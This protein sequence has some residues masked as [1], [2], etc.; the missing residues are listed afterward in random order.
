MNQAAFSP[1]IP[2]CSHDMASYLSESSAKHEPDA[3]MQPQDIMMIT[4][5]KNVPEELKMFL[6]THSDQWYTNEQLAEQLNQ[7]V[8]LSDLL[9]VRPLESE[10]QSLNLS[11]Q[12]LLRRE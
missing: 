7:Y 8:L 3:V 11:R 9:I 12:V 1:E 2:L 10:M 5:P 6:M 4:K